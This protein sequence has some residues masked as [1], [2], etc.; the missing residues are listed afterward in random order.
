[1][2][3]AVARVSPASVPR[4]RRP[5]SGANSAP[6]PAGWPSLTIAVSSRALFDLDGEHATF[7][8]RGLSAYRHQQLERQDDLPAPGPAFLLSKSLL[9]LNDLAGTGDRL[10][11]VT[12]ISRNSP[13]MALR[14]TRAARH[15][16]LDIARWAFTSGEPVAKY[17]VP[18]GI[19]LFLSREEAAVQEALEA[20]IAAAQLYRLPPGLPSSAPFSPVVFAFDADSVLFSDE[21]ERIYQT[22]GLDAFRRYEEANAL[23]PMAEGP[24]A[25]L[26]MTLAT[27][28]KI[29]AASGRQL[30]RIVVVTARDAPAHERVF[31]T[32]QAWKIS[33]DQ[34]FMMGGLSKAPILREVQPHIFFDDQRRHTD[35]AAAHVPTGLVVT[36]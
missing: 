4:R 26:L 33:V 17:L 3:A 35:Q 11:S 2:A 36:K 28:Q 20:G 18:Y 12:L 15:Y 5:S 16:G 8:A 27:I 21:S 19:D 25:R 7:E 34:L 10:V 1:M 13:E 32:L 23:Q 6:A 9:A 14:L 30:V 24:F 22:Q 31:H 29:G